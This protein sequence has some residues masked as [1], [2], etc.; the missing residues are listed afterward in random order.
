MAS[1]RLLFSAYDLAITAA[2]A[3]VAVA[4]TI[5][6][7]QPAQHQKGSLTTSGETPTLTSIPPTQFAQSAGPIDALGVGSWPAW[8]RVLVRTYRDTQEDRLLA[9]AA[10]VVFYLL[11]AVFPAL[12]AC[13]SIY[14]LFAD[15]VAVS[16]HLSLISDIVPEGAIAI[17]GE[18]IQRIIGHGSGALTFGFLT[19][20][21]LALWSANSGVKALIDALNAIYDQPERRSFMKLN[22]VSLIFTIGSIIVAQLLVAGVVITPLVLAYFGIASLAETVAVYGRWA[23]LFVLVLL[24]FSLLYRFGPCRGGPRPRWITAGSVLATLLW[25]ISS[26]AFSYYLANFGNYN[27]TYG[28]LGAAIG[29]MMW[30]WISVAI[31]LLGAEFDTEI[32]R[33][34]SSVS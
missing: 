2:A 25:I 33:E 8:K 28:S 23:V 26:A 7:Q 4:L 20:L 21:A 14:G 3:F 11:L 1:S 18:Q 16:N 22:A 17:I 19:S 27:A 31:L 24:S 29:M 10:G 5:R 30:M 32:E 15:P 6:L 9:V 34:L 12:T 13:I